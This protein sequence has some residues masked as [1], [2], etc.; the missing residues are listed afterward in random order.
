MKIFILVVSLA[1]LSNFAIS[2]N[3]MSFK[4]DY[5]LYKI[6]G[7]N[8]SKD[9][10]S[11]VFITPFEGNRFVIRGDNWVGIGVINENKGYYDWRFDDGKTGQTTFTINSDGSFIGKV[12]GYSTDPYSQGL[13]WVYKAIKK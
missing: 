1:L 12:L 8:V 3:I 5:S 6:N 4:G 7:D 11:K 2:Q 9:V 10:T 13:D